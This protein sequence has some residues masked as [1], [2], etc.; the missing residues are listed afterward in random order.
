MQELNCARIRCGHESHLQLACLEKALNGLNAGQGLG[1]TVSGLVLDKKSLALGLGGGASTLATALLA[2]GDDT[3]VSSVGTAA[4][5]LS[6]EH[7]GLIRGFALNASCSYNV[8]INEVLA[9]H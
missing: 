9:G 5:A 6:A 3:P 2:F 8:T 4:C 1:F 7:T